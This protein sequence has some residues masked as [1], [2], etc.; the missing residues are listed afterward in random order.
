MVEFDQITKRYGNLTA[1]DEVSFSIEKGELFALL[2]PNGAGKTTLVKMLLDFT[3]PS[4]GGVR[5][6]DLPVSDPSSRVSVGY[7]AEN[8]RLPGHLTGRDYL[9]RCCRLLGLDKE[10]SLEECDRVFE[11]IG[12][13]GRERTATRTYSKGMTQRMTLGAAL[14]GSPRLVILDEPTSGLDPIGI[15]EVREVLES[16]RRQGTTVLLNSH[17]LSEVEKVCD[18]AAI[19]SNGRLLVKDKISSIVKDGESLEDVFIRLVRK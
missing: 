5:I 16:L 11:T 6:N 19:L 7:Q 18:T 3:R 15:R 2:G 13:K 10:Q 4:Q 9:L 12:M 1:V 17:L 14:L 8:P